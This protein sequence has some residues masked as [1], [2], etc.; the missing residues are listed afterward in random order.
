M[1]NL[2]GWEN[3]TRGVQVALI[4]SEKISR[5]NGAQY[6]ER[7]HLLSAVLQITA[8]CSDEE[9]AK[10]L[11]SLLTIC[12]LNPEEI[13]LYADA[14]IEKFGAPLSERQEFSK[15]ATLALEYA[16][17]ESSRDQASK[18]G[19]EHLFIALITPQRGSHLDATL[20]PLKLSDKDIRQR[21][22]NINKKEVPVITEGMGKVL[23]CAQTA[24]R[25]TFC[26][27]IAP[28]HLLIGILENPENRACELLTTANIDLLELK[29]K[30]QRSVVNDNENATP[31]KRYSKS[32]QRALHRA[33]NIARKARYRFTAPEHL[34]LALLPQEA[35]F[36][37]KRKFGDVEELDDFW[38]DTDI[39]TIR[40]LIENDFNVE[41]E[42]VPISPETSAYYNSLEPANYDKRSPFIEFYL[43]LAMSWAM[44][45]FGKRLGANWES[46]IVVGGIIL[47]VLSGLFLLGTQFFS[48][49]H[50][51]KRR[52]ISIFASILVGLFLGKSTS[53]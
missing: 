31:Q 18:I 35:S 22:H 16:V 1:N 9:E 8:Q 17:V 3:F 47:I 50:Q 11:N 19:L 42:P 32:A 28:L 7:E 38:R 5:Q 13:G 29:Q 12:N 40:T 44:I 6:I 43:P 34:L 25:L 45:Y 48:R 30:A 21:L 26:G 51:L 49:N 10:R 33:E 27:R 14:A 52:G 36:R 20:K 4:A 2:E 39:E 37:E 41:A 24:M 23:E 53:P 15:T 46:L